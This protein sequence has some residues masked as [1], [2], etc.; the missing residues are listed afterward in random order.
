MTAPGGLNKRW[1]YFLDKA[2]AVVV[3][4]THEFNMEKDDVDVTPPA[5][6]AELRREPVPPPGAGG[7]LGYSQWQA[8]D[9]SGS[10]ATNPSVH[11]QIH[12]VG[13]PIGY[14]VPDWRLGAVAKY[15]YQYYAEDRFKGQEFTLT[16]GYPFF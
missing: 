4:A 6:L 14:S 16:V 10:D 1:S 7:I 5:L 15:L 9:D 3:A 8:R 2:M 11:D 13:A 12:A